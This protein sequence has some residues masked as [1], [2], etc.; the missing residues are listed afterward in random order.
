MANNKK[1]TWI[2]F[3]V[4]AV[5]IILALAVFFIFGP[6]NQNTQSQNTL[7]PDTFSSCQASI[8]IMPV[9]EGATFT[10]K[11]IGT[12]SENCHW[13]FLLQTSN[14]SQ[15]KDCNYPTAQMSND[16][17]YHLFGQ[18]KTDMEC[19]SDICKQQDSLQ[20]TYCK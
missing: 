16:T 9:G 8:L 1:K 6:E 13:Q 12:E 18:D 4:L 10:I 19:L 7:T 15:T 3:V 20:D 17:F 14:L 5:V 11:V 2:T